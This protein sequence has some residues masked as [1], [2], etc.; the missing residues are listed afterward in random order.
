MRTELPSRSQPLR[1]GLGRGTRISFMKAEL[2]AGS[3]TPFPP[4]PVE[5]ANQPRYGEGRRISKAVERRRDAVA[6]SAA[7]RTRPTG[8]IRPRGRTNV[9]TAAADG[10]A[11]QHDSF[12]LR[13][14]SR[15]AATLNCKLMARTTV[16]RTSLLS[17]ACRSLKLGTSF[18]SDRQSRLGERRSIYTG[19]P[20]TSGSSPH[21]HSAGYG[22]RVVG[23]L[24]Q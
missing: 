11:S 17:G 21:P 23:P 12:A 24:R 7:A 19:V 22:N 13:Q 18:T 6:S 4:H 5:A 9:R 2:E 14:T 3:F 10:H 20:T 1:S 8:Q 15:S 16:H